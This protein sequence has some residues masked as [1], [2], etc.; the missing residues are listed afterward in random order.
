MRGGGGSGRR[1]P[2][3]PEDEPFPP[4]DRGAWRRH[5]PRDFRRRIGFVFLAFFLI[6]F[7]TSAVA[8]GVLTDVFGV[9]PHHGLV[10]LA[11]LFA[12]LILG[13]FAV[14]VRWLRRMA[15]PVEDVMA[16]ADR[17]AGGD[18]SVRVAERGPRE[19]RRLARSFN[20]MTGRL[21]SDEERRRALLADV[22]HELRTP[23]SVIQGNTE[24]MIDGLYPADLT[25]LTTVLEETKVMAR[26]LQDLQTLSTAEAGA[27][28]LYREPTTAAR[29]T[30][31]AIATFA[32]AAGEKGVDLRSRVDDGLPELHVDPFRIGEVLANLLSNA[33]R[34]TP[35]GGTVT[36][37]ASRD[38][39]SVS[40][41][42]ADTGPGIPTEQL[43]H[44]FDRYVKAAD[45]GGSGLGLAIARTL[46]EA[47][48]GTIA[49]ANDSA[50]GATIRFTL[51]AGPA[52]P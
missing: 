28:V 43:T 9:R 36:V 18:Y 39:S 27:L 20:E 46:V 21:G 44:V 41:A 16:A 22:A 49:A 14:F 51:P 3:W 8:V 5:A 2:W 34:H 42:V 52:S 33:L 40:F 12:V 38:G 15:A 4:T 37:A 24:G 13:G 6:L 19:M 30:D 45:T 10:P 1:P 32:A 50:G 7:L 48:G 29:L 31:D 35:S 11:A 23:L 26:L 17:V 47:H 25:H